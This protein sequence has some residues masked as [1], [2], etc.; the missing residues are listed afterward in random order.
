MAKR[1]SRKLKGLPDGRFSDGGGLHY[2]K[3]GSS[4]QWL[5]RW[6]RNGTPKEITLADASTTGLA[7]ADVD[8]GL[9]GPG[10]GQQNH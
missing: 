9:D 2:R 8:T 6:M 4:T 7:G 10:G 5:F 3:R 1:T